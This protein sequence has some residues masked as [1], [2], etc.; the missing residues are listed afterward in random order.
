MREPGLPVDGAPA[1]PFVAFE[2]DR[3][4][5]STAPDHR[6]RC[7]AEPRP[8]PRALAHQ[9]AYCLSSAFAVCPTFQDWARR[10]A[11]AARPSAAS[12]GPVAGAPRSDTDPAIER[13]ALPPPEREARHAPASSVPP[14]PPHRPAPRDWAAPPP[15]LNPAAREGIR[16]DGAPA[17]PPPFLTDRPAGRAVAE[18]RGSGAAD[19]GRGLTGPDE[20]RGLAGSD[21]DRIASGLAGSGADR[22]ASGRSGSTADRSAAA[23]Q[24]DAGAGT[25]RLG[26]SPVPPERVAAERMGI[27]AWAGH[28]PDEDLGHEA[29]PSPRRIER[30]DRVPAERPD[31]TPPPSRHAPERREDAGAL[32]G[33]SWEQP[34][35]FEAYPSLRRRVGL[36]SLPGSSVVVGF[37]ALILAAAALFFLPAFLGVGDDEPGATPTPTPAASVTPPPEPTP[38]P[39]PTPTV[40]V[41]AAGET[42]SKIA[43]DYG[44]TLDE[45]LAANPQITDADRIAI[46]DEVIIPAAAPSVP[47][48]VG[49]EVTPAP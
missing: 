33:P 23:G 14:L 2:D 44:L 18:G 39:A 36:P 32:R 45:L 31:Y 20:G 38:T 6:H 10:E 28:E 5:R 3:D 46:G 49:G 21:A 47:A 34:R 30:R 24:A 9:E 4:A 8:A 19:G 27:D 35:R 41:V 25:S 11:A 37:V 22:V 13:A 26:S 16:P 17:T 43:S 7:Y 29:A 48:E 12:P 15:W 42:L 1:C 40:H